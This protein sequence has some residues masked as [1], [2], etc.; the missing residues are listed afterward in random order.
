MSEATSRAPA[1]NSGAR[2]SAVPHRRVLIADDNADAA[3]SLAM[4]LRF[5]GHEVTVVPNGRQA[6]AR[7][8]EE[9]PEF[10]LLDIGMP[11]V[12]GY[13]VARQ[14]REL[15]LRS[16]PTLIAVT[17]WGQASDKT[18]AQSAGFDFHFTKPIEPDD[19]FRLLRRT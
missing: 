5:E 17:G 9:S 13:E 19:L 8:S 15:P 3:D 4:L 14:I 10:V 6:L 1:E 2:M 12:D 11:D 18:R 7:V 16:R